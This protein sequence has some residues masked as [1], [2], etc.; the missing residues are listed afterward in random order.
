MSV[1]QR[2]VAEA[3][4]IRAQLN[5][6]ALIARTWQTASWAPTAHTGVLVPADWD[7]NPDRLPP[8]LRAAVENVPGDGSCLYHCFVRLLKLSTWHPLSEALRTTAELREALAKFF[9]ASGEE[10]NTPEYRNTVRSALDASNPEAVTYKDAM[11][12]YAATIR[13]D[14][15]GGDLE[16]NMMSEMLGVI[17][18]RFEAQGDETIEEA[19]RVTTFFPDASLSD[20][21]RSVSKWTVV[22]TRNHFQ[23]VRPQ[24]PRNLP[25]ASPAPGPSTAPPA[26]AAR[27]AASGSPSMSVQERAEMI[28]KIHK[29][30][31]GAIGPAESRPQAVAEA[32]RERMNREAQRHSNN[33]SSCYRVATLTQEQLDMQA[34]IELAYKL[35]ARERQQESDAR[36][37]RRL[38]YELNLS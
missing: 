12:A 38:Q 3:E 22:W 5:H 24:R 17:I 2:P 11:P 16:I 8:A 29:K 35:D 27:A 34:S 15:W 36:L 19:R 30:K 18:H 10:Y 7:G 28:R 21:G 4:L 25:N 13:G 20:R 1:R 23:Y 9:E 6:A 32:A 37:A 33:T 31:A 14:T 26:P